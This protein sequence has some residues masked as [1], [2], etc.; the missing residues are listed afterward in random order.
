MAI[1]V[2]TFVENDFGTSSAQ[3]VIFKSKWFELLLVLFSITLIVNIFRFRMVQ[4]KKWSILTFHASMVIIVIG[5]GVTRYFGSEGMMGIRE[6]SASNSFLSAESYLLFQVMHQGKKYAF[7]EPVLFATL[8]DNTLKKEYVIGNQTM[9]VEVTD[10]VPN[11]PKLWWTT[12]RACPSSK[13]S[14]PG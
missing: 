11:P 6:G 10:F 4:Q 1:G 14:S 7:D 12:K 9:T 3:K 13:W 2:A 8:G 5:A